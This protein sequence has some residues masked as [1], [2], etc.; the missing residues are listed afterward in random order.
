[1]E[2]SAVQSEMGS[3]D[4]A[5]LKTHLTNEL[6]AQDV[7]DVNVTS[8]SGVSDVTADGGTGTTGSVDASGASGFL[9]C[10][11]GMQAI[12]FI[13]TLLWGLA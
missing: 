1:M 7:L 2:T 12:F 11:A 6:I 8:V 9:S 4:T 5:T 3:L 10:L 13:G